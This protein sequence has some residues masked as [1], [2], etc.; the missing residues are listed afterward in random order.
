MQ[1]AMS[2]RPLPHRRHLASFLADRDFALISIGYSEFLSVYRRQ[3][4]KKF[5]SADTRELFAPEH[6]HE[7]VTSNPGA[8]KDPSR[9]IRND[10][11]Y[12]A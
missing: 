6:V 1:P 7:A 5:E 2:S 11:P 4:G 8:E 12:E 3:S 9:I 10:L